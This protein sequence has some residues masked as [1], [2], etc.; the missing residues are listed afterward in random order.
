MIPDNLNTKDP[1]MLGEDIPDCD[2]F[3]STLWLYCFANDF[4]KNTGR[5]YKKVLTKFEGYHLWFYF[6]EQDSNDVAENIV[7]K[8]V[9]EP[10]YA[11]EINKNIIIEADKLRKYCETIPQENLDKL[12][13]EELW[14]IYKKHNEIHNHY[15]T[16]CW[17]PVAAD[18]F[19]NNL[20]NRLKN[21]LENKEI[22]QDKINEYFV[23]L[24]QPTNKS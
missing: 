3:F 20:T 24:T 23:I 7:N 13:N 9:N 8:I 2:L 1:W 10:N 17:I 19:H 15:Y 5:A 14:Q 12:N 4:K 6:G 22:K 21:Y 16:W 11:G 18:M